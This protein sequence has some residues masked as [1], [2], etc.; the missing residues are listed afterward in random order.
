MLKDGGR[1]VGEM[2]G[3]LNVIGTGC[4]HRVARDRGLDPESMDP[5]YFPTIEGYQKVGPKYA[6]E[7][8]PSIVP[9]ISF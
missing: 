3:Y 7:Q 9:T 5:W 4:L 1:F 8:Q 6:A 2:G